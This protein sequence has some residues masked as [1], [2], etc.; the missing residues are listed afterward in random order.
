M[1]QPRRRLRNLGKG[2]VCTLALLTAAGFTAAGAASAAAAPVPVGISH[3]VRSAGL[4]Q[5]MISW[6]PSASTT[7]VTVASGPGYV[8]HM[9]PGNRV[10]LTHI[11]AGAGLDIVITAHGASGSVAR[12]IDFVAVGVN[13]SGGAVGKA[14]DGRLTLSVDDEWYFDGLSVRGD[15]H[16]PPSLVH[17]HVLVQ[18]RSPGHPWHT[19][20]RA[21]TDEHGY[22]A[23]KFYVMPKHGALRE[24]YL[25]HGAY[26]GF[27]GPALR[28]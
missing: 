1:S 20:G 9:L 7:S 6:T 17:S 5:A 19:V 18:M 23:S 22:A 13:A 10:R 28:P 12:I 8:A 26:L 11:P 3:I 2:S 24:V 15:D 25:G 27:D 4:G 16:E 14:V 21:V